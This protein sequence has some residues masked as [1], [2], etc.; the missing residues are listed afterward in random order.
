MIPNIALRLRLI[1][2]FFSVKMVLELLKFYK[3]YKFEKPSQSFPIFWATTNQPPLILA[4]IPTPRHDDDD[5]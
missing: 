2:I 4:D 1:N 5:C 3:L